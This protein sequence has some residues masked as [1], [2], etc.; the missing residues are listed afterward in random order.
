MHVGMDVLPEY[1]WRWISSSRAF[2]IPLLDVYSFH[3]TFVQPRFLEHLLCERY[4]SRH[5]GYTDDTKLE[6]SAFKEFTF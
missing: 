5:L 3:S 6:I 2:E 1:R 4:Y